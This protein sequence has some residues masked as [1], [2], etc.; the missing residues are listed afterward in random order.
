MAGEIEANLALMS[1]ELKVWASQKKISV[2]EGVLLL[3]GASP[4][5]VFTDALERSSVIPLYRFYLNLIE[6]EF[7]GL[8]FTSRQVSP[9][10]F[11]EMADACKA[12]VPAS[13]REAILL[14]RRIELT[15]LD[16]PAIA[17]QTQAITDEETPD[18]RLLDSLY[19]IIFALVVEKYRYEPDAPRS[20]VPA[21]IE[22]VM[23]R[24]GFK[25]SAKTIRIHLRA[26]ADAAK[27]RL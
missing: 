3:L 2:E 27:K 10:R 25:L 7:V 22:A 8:E 9:S 5:Y 11:L 13:V 18:P 24:Q 21:K 1:G 14:N 15:T 4:R 17:P 16:T 20:E 23:N 6:R 26:A 19:S 12:K